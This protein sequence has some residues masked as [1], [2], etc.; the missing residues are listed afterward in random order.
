MLKL[1]DLKDYSVRTYASKTL[2][3]GACIHAP[4]STC[5]CTGFSLWSQQCLT[6]FLCAVCYTVLIYTWPLTVPSINW[7][8]TEFLY[9]YQLN[10]DW[11]WILFI[12]WALTEFIHHRLHLRPSWQGTGWLQSSLTIGPANPYKFIYCLKSFYL[13]FISPYPNFSVLGLQ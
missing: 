1:S 3:L 12:D 7:T 5:I 8:L 11:V 6:C 13:Y 10:L 4:G 9:I 2:Q